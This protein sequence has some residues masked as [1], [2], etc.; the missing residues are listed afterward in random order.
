LAQ[1]YTAVDPRAE[2]DEAR[3]VPLH[4]VVAGLVILATLF[5]GYGT[6]VPSYVIHFVARPWHLSSSE[7]GFLVSAGLIGFAVGAVSHGPIA[8]RAG[9]RPTLIAGLVIGGVFSILTA[10]VGDSFGIFVTL[11]ILTGVG[12]GV[13]MPLGT[14]YVNEFMPRRHSNR[15]AT[16][17]TIGF[18]AGA[19]I[20]SILGIYLTPGRGWPVL[21]WCGGAALPIALLCWFF[22]PESVQYLTIKK[23]HEKAAAVLSRL[24]PQERPRYEGAVFA[25]PRD[26]PTEGAII[27]LVTSPRYLR[28]TIVLWVA[29]FVVLFDI[30]G[31]SGWTPTIMISRGDSFAAGFSFGA[32][33]QG[34]GIVGGLVAAQVAD[35][36]GERRR[37]LIWWL[38]AGTL[39]ALVVSLVTTTATNIVFI[40]LAGFFIIGGQFLLNNMCAH[41]YPTEVRGTGQGLMLGIGRIGGILGPYFGG[42]LLGWFGGN[43]GALFEAVAVATAIGVAAVILL[44]PD[45][46]PRTSAPPAALST[47]G[48]MHP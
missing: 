43:S 2:L 17:G 35:R 4:W 5:D 34:M 22:L 21:F 42:W 29:A 3:L 14:A 27:K 41:A 32:I 1:E 24:R 16:L 28:T 13:L 6:L 48:E 44:R 39:S 40:G 18:S 30:Y 12:L 7:A 33:L 8:D 26:F 15:L 11:R 9:R 19:V 25:Q 10:A 36:R 31:L 47:A 23:R 38:I 46:S 20:A 37:P 45:R